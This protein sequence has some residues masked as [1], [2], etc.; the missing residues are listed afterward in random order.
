MIFYNYE[1]SIYKFYIETFYSPS[2]SPSLPLPLSVPFHLFLVNLRAS[3]LLHGNRRIRA[4][5]N[6]T[7]C[8]L[9]PFECLYHGGE[10]PW[11]ICRG[12]NSTIS[13][14]IAQCGDSFEFC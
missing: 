2:P 13:R 4:V 14:F 1:Q 3:L 12:L 11:D 7:R 6:C 9:M 10:K 5:R 8:I